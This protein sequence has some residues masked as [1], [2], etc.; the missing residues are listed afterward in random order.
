L[1]VTDK[2][3]ASGTATTSVSVVDQLPL[4]YQENLQYLGA[5][6][7]PSGTFGDSVFDYGGTALAFN[8]AHNSLFIVGHDWDQAVAEIAIPQSIVN[9]NSLN[10]LATASV[11]QPFVKVLGRAPNNTLANRTVKI[12]G[13]MVVNGGLIGTAYD[14]YDALGTARDSHFK[15][16]SLSLATADVTGY[17]QVGNLGGGFVGGYMAPVPAQWQAAF[18]APYLTGQ[19]ALTVIGRTSA[20]PAAFGFD[21]NALGSSA[22]PATPYV[23]YPLGHELGAMVGAADPLFNGATWV[24]GVFFAPGTRSIL[25]FGSNGTG[26]IGYG[27]AAAFNDTNRTSK[28]YHA[29]NGQYRY[30]AWAY[31][32]DDFLAVKNGIKQP[33]QIRPYEV[34]NFDF[35]ISE[36]AKHIGGVAFDAATGRLYVSQIGGDAVGYGYKPLIQVFQLDFNLPGAPTLKAPRISSVTATPNTVPAGSSVT[37]TARDITEPN[38]VGSITQVEFY[39]DLNRDGV[40][41]PSADLLLGLGALTNGGWQLTFSTGGL[42][43][44]TYTVFARAKDSNGVF[45]DL[46]AIP[47]GVA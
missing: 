31:T 13:L 14:Y 40:F 37:L 45:S 3:N 24:N 2:D 28:G 4:I 46:F 43:P 7:V 8:P 19:A 6:R 38:A 44:G 12:G 36:G 16:S 25:F 11:L 29:V 34:W 30:Q 18:G 5:F 1:T 20:G 33:W 41:Y 42:P 23:Y 27:E 32:V 47:V 17:F 10:N 21:P 15:L 9:S 39:L 22:A 35:P 26:Q